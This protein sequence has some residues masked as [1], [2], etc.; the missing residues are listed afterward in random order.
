MR[1]LPDVP[2]LV[3]EGACFVLHAPRQSGKTTALLTLARELTREGRYTGL[4]VSVEVGQ[5]FGDDIGRMDGAILGSWTDKADV[6]LPAEL[7]PPALPAAEPGQCVSRSLKTW[8]LSS[9]RPIVLFVDEIDSLQGAALISLLRQIRDGYAFRPE[10]FPWSLAPMGVRE[11]REYKVAS[12][13]SDRLGTASP[14]NIKAESLTLANFIEA[15]VQ[16]L[17]AQHT[18]GD[19][20]DR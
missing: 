18:A 3:E 2:R 7:R 6:Y 9:P 17:Y 12:G 19:L 8:A 20:L 16:E 11:V 15:D 5:P 14:F 4:P 10:G 1:R 13:G